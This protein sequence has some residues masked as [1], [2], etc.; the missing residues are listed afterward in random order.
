M[1]ALKLFPWLV[2]ALVAACSKQ[3]P[4]A[5]AVMPEVSEV[6]CTPEAIKAIADEATRKKFAG[7]CLRRGSLQ[8]GPDEGL[9]M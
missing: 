6:N 7:L 2:L 8:K 1:K 9:K 4:P 5:P 3:E